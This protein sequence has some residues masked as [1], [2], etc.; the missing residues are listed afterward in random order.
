MRIPLVPSRKLVYIGRPAE[1]LG[2]GALTLVRI[3]QTFALDT[4]WS[5][6]HPAIY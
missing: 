4:F 6:A 5:F 2:R 1:A 3:H